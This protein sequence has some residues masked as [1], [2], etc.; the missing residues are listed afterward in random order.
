[1]RKKTVSI[2]SG[3]ETPCY[4]YDQARITDNIRQLQGYFSKAEISIYYAVKANT[5][6]AVLKTIRSQGLGA[7]AVSAGEI[8]T[9]IKAGFA[10]RKILYNNI[11]RKD[12]DIAYALKMGIHY[13]NFE[14]LDQAELL[15]RQARRAGRRIKIFV[16]INPGIFSETHP[17]LSTG[18]LSSKFGINENQLDSVIK[19]SRRLRFARLIG[20]HCHI[21]SQ[22]LQPAPFVKAVNRVRHYIE[23]LR[24][25]GISITH[26]NLG[27]GFGVPHH[28]D[29]N[30]LDFRPITEAYKGLSAM[31]NVKVF[32]EPGRFIVSNAGYILSRIIS[33]KIVNR[34]RMYIIDAGMTENPRPALYDAYH[35]IE[36]LFKKFDPYIR[37]RVTGPLCENSDE[38]GAYNLPDLAIGDMLLIHNCGAYTR[39]MASNYNGRLL[40]AEYMIKGQ[41]VSLIRKQQKY[42]DLVCNEKY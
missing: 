17:H 41:R 13:F 30:R 24:D 9:A 11:A 22:I 15:E 37:H 2:I 4:V 35:H 38:F 32:L 6:L 26:V 27:G 19:L 8:F 7:E 29:E 1:M 31:Q 5:S 34:K 10:S 3:L 39:T 12:A 40:P 33:R 25:A 42:P 14:A 20:I 18:A 28:P 36:P 21:G 23:I 16:R